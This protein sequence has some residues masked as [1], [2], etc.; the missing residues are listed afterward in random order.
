MGLL[1]FIHTD[2]GV[3]SPEVEHS[4]A[5]AQASESRVTAVWGQRRFCAP[6]LVLQPTSESRTP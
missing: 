5:G 3:L 6:F 1:C 2:P 4:P